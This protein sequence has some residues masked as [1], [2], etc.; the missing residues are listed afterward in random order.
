[1]SYG[2]LYGQFAPVGDNV[3]E[4]YNRFAE[5]PTF[6]ESL[7]P[8][9]PQTVQ[10]TLD[11][12]AQSL[13]TAGTQ[14]QYQFTISDYDVE[15]FS[16][17]PDSYGLIEQDNITNSTGIL[18]LPGELINTNDPNGGHE[19]GYPKDR[20]IYVKCVAQYIQNGQVVHASAPYLIAITTPKTP[21]TIDWFDKEVDN[22]LEAVPALT[23]W[24]GSQLD[25]FIANVQQAGANALGAVAQLSSLAQELGGKATAL[26]NALV[27]NPSKFLATLQQ[28][29][30]GAITK[31]LDDLPDTLQSGFFAWLLGSSSLPIS[32][33]NLGT[34]EGITAFLLSYSGLTWD[35]IQSVL[36]QELGAGN[37]A[38]AAA[39]ANWLGNLDTSDPNT[40]AT[41]FSNLQSQISGLDPQTLVQD[42]IIPKVTTNLAQALPLAMAQLAAKF[43]PGAG[44]INSIFQGISWLLA[45]ARSMGDT[46]TQMLN[47]LD[48]LTTY[49]AIAFQ[50]KLVGV[51]E[52]ASTVKIVLNFA[53]S[54][55]GL[56]SIPLAIQNA[57]SIVPNQ[58]D[59]T[60]RQ[61]VSSIAKSVGPGGGT[62]GGLFDGLLG[63]PRT[64]IDKLNN[65]SYILWVAQNAAGFKIKVA[66]Q[67]GANAYK[68]IADLTTLN[69]SNQIVATAT[70]DVQAVSGAS[71]D[72]LNKSKA[73]GTSGALLKQAGATLTSAE[74]QLANDCSAGACV[75]LNGC[76]AAGTKLWTPQGFRV[77]EEILE[78]ELVFSR[79]EF[80]V[81]GPI[82][83]KLVAAKFD[84]VGRLLHVHLANGKI[85]KTTPEHP[86]FVYDKEW[87]EAGALKTGEWVRTDNGWTSV[88]EVFDTGLYE[89]V[90]NLRVADWH[91]YFVGEEGSDG[92]VW[93]HNQICGTKE[94]AAARNASYARSFTD[95]PSITDPANIILKA[96][97]QA[98][99][100]PAAGSPGDNATLAYVEVAGS[101][102]PVFASNSDSYSYNFPT[103]GTGPGQV[104]AGQGINVQA[105]THAEIKAMIHAVQSGVSLRGK[106]ITIFTDRD[107]CSFCDKSRGIENAAR[108]FGVTSVT[109][110]CPSGSII[111]NL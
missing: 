86:F 56:S 76:F 33:F 106:S 100:M 81:D 37:V 74:G 31:F 75:T 51:L 65:N 91:T 15:Q 41:F 9:A 42:V 73:A 13:D 93:A 32:S 99:G 12:G 47:S 92:N 107:P 66:Q 111:I 58:V 79:S 69:F 53:A 36:A 48:P 97:R 7:A 78:G 98:R 62:K 60:L 59:K 104:P 68:F 70:N 6:S 102:S 67:T 4:T 19:T 61:G 87:T 71:Q 40:I 16:I 21:T 30:E 5:T 8:D 1:M 10:M 55:L 72:L 57:L 110:W 108:V 64:F 45:N 89:R 95:V 54:Q 3:P 23:Q 103:V 18:Q 80:E 52:N 84:R 44:A 35:N 2:G 94:T 29:L 105:Q 14:V 46:L 90:Y 77:V 88:E 25:T 17:F 63:L 20:L 24:A 96:E 27:N 101:S 28:G 26:I 34:T 83:A 38:A 11:Q 22:A 50:N 109:I 49:D 82:V 39:V 43:L 85:I